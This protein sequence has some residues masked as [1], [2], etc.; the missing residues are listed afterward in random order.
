MKPIMFALMIA[1]LS[2][3]AAT[4][5]FVP[6]AEACSGKKKNKP[7]SAELA[8]VPKNAQSR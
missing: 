5:A 4:T 6:T 8:P 3:T 2:A 7:A 1:T